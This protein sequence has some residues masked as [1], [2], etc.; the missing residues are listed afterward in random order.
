L[1]AAIRFRGCRLVRPPIRGGRVA[2]QNCETQ[3]LPHPSATRSACGRL[4]RKRARGSWCRAV[5]LRID[6]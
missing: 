3:V 2:L 6:E 1:Y 4:S 5:S